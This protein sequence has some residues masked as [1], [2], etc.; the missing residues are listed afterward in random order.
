MFGLQYR[1]A[2]EAIP[3]FYPCASCHFILNSTYIYVFLF[4]RF[5]RS[6]VIEISLED[7]KVVLKEADPYLSKL[8]LSAQDALKPLGS[9]SFISNSIFTL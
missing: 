2:Q 8:T 6:R 7:L 3:S 9:P 5:I 1:L 4:S